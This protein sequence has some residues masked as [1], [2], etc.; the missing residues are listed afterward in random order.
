MIVV[1]GLVS[2]D[3]IAA[4]LE[5]LPSW[6]LLDPIE[7]IEVQLGGAVANT[8]AAL[9]R[10]GIPVGTIYRIGEDPLGEIIQKSIATWATT[11]WVTI[12]PQAPT[13]ATVVLL[14]SDGD[15][16][17]L[18]ASGAAIH[19]QE[20]D[21][22]LEALCAQGARALHLGYALLLPALDGAPMARLLCKAQELGLLTSLDV[23]STPNLNWPLL[24]EV[25]PCVD[26]FCPNHHEAQFVTQEKDPE[27]AAEALL[28]L[29]VRQVVAI[30]MGAQ[31]AYLRPAKRSGVWL[32]AYP[33]RPVDTTGAGDAFIGGLLAAWYRGLD[34][35]EAGR[36]ASIVGAL[37]TT[38]SGAGRG[39]ETWDEVVARL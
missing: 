6:G 3:L 22:P 2:A 26:A 19:F 31:G 20:G 32:P 16:A 4:P 5:R 14:K 38:A 1:A 13:P 36:I 30:K 11:Q 15:R 9:H 18:H 21:V 24:K 28:N 23:T 8:G 33:V 37:A 17:F 39:I 29:G 7:R 35:L 10:L 25:L 12:D 34:W 27:Q